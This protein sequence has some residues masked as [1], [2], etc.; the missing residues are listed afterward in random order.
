M[1]RN[2]CAWEGS[3][4]KAL[5]AILG[6]CVITF[7]TA[8]AQEFVPSTPV[9]VQGKPLAP[10]Q[11]IEERCPPRIYAEGEFLMWRTK[12]IPVNTPLVTQGT[13]F[14]AD[15]TSGLLSSANTAILMG[16]QSYDL[17][18]RTGARLTIGGWF[19]HD[20]QCGLEG[21][22]FYIPRKST[23]QSVYSDGSPGSAVLKVPFFNAIS[24]AEDAIPLS[25]S[26]S[27]VIRDQRVNIPLAGSA[28]LNVAN[29][30]QGAELNGVFRILQQENCWSLYGLAG[31]RWI[32]FRED[33][34]FGTARVLS[35][36]AVGNTP[37]QTLA[38][39]TQDTFSAKNNFYGGQLG[40]RG[41]RRFHNFTVE[42]TAKIALGY[43]YETMD[44]NGVSSQ[45]RSIPVPNSNF[46][47]APGGIFAQQTNMGHFSHG[48]FCVVPELKLKLGYDITPHIQ[49]FVAYDVL[50]MTSVARPRTVISHQINPSLVPVISGFPNNPV[51]PAAPIFA[52]NQNN[53]WAQGLNVG[54]QIRY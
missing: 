3:M 45:A 8:R 50:Y 16:N 41:E 37:A 39:A 43:N 12:N 17:G 36:P 13:N 5:L 4:K 21:S 46:T 38:S 52:F 31:A 25:Q 26:T 47:N 29:Q 30:I 35:L 24:L 27:A 42:G 51:P 28:Y 34:E 6:I 9:V 54:L 23:S 19:D 20:A 15:P 22:Y 48:N 32:Y 14:P 11:P 7:Q 2:Y 18:Y 53:F 10:F 44:I 1:L 40:L 49:I 33:L